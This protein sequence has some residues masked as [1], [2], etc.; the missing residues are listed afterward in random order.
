LPQQ[1]GT[2]I[3]VLTILAPEDKYVEFLQGLQITA[4]WFSDEDCARL[5]GA[6]KAWQSLKPSCLKRDKGWR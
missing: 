4:L 6:G 2:D 5:G 1:A 3:A